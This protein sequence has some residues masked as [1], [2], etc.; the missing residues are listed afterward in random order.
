[1]SEQNS[2]FQSKIF[3][4]SVALNQISAQKSC[5]ETQSVWMQVL[6]RNQFVW[7]KVFLRNPNC[8]NKSFVL[9]S[10]KMLE[11]KFS[12]ECN[13]F[14]Q[15]CCLKKLKKFRHKTLVQNLNA[16][17]QVFL[18]IPNVWTEVIF[19]IQTVWIKCFLKTKMSE[20]W[21]SHCLKRILRRWLLWWK[22]CVT[23][24]KT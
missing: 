24:P 13:F 6:L 7:D 9:L 8:L 17:T 23:S 2:F 14:E 21:N 5:F 15:Y 20:L 16:W 18:L 1:M 12:F 3:N 19:S 10:T 22:L 11:E 4:R